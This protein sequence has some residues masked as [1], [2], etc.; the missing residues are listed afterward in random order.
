MT[1][2]RDRRFAT[3]ELVVAETGAYVPEQQAYLQI[4][5]TA[6]ELAAGLQA[7]LAADGL[8][9][10]QYNALRAIRR[11]GD[12]GLTVGE[13]GRQLTRPGADVTRLVDRLV[14]EDL[15]ARAPAA[16]RRA[17]RVRLTEAG[18]ARLAALDGPILDL[19]RAQLGHLDPDELDTLV[20]LLRRARGEA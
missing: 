3:P 8:S 20:G 19:H 5:R 4:V 15:V 17:V 11:A 9:G 13:I 16:D 1:K 12:T 7:L 2:S 10:L 6:E 18:A 14:R